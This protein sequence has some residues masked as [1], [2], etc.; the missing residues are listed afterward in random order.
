ME[1]R[2][3]DGLSREEVEEKEEKKGIFM[4]IVLFRTER[5]RF[6]LHF[7]LVYDF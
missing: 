3:K 1:S 4:A 6:N 7:S 5:F 2:P